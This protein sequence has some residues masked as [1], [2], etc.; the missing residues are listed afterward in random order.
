MFV[1]SHTITPITK[2]ATMVATMTPLFQVLCFQILCSTSPPREFS[3][4]GGRVLT[5]A[6]ILLPKNTNVRAAVP[7]APQRN[8]SQPRTAGHPL[9]EAFAHKKIECLF[10]A[11][12][13]DWQVRP[14]GRLA[15]LERGEAY[16]L[17]LVYSGVQRPSLAGRTLQTRASLLLQSR[18]RNF[19]IAIPFI[20]PPR[21]G[22]VGYGT[23]LPPSS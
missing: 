18:G 9:G 7:G 22:R 11:I 15:H 13:G 2:A 1:A 10:D 23:G 4:D 8:R 12:V 19:C 5:G 20:V 6:S 3:S 21:G 16:P 17:T 14:A